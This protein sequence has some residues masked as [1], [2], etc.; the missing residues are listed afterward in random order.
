VVVQETTTLITSINMAQC[1][2][3]GAKVGCS[4]QLIKGL[5]TYCSKAAQKAAQNSKYVAIKLN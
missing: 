3:C 1:S 2:K 4:C 5:C